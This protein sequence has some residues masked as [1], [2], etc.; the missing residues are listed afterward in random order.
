VLPTTPSTGSIFHLRR[1]FAQDHDDRE[2]LQVPSATP[3]AGSVNENASALQSIAA[4]ERSCFDV[5]GP[6]KSSIDVAFS[7][8]K[9][10]RASLPRGWRQFN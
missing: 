10:A 3:G 4:R 9:M 8:A 5:T 1:D 6:V 2:G 7:N